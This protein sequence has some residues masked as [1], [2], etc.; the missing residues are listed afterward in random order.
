MEQEGRL[1]RIPKLILLP[2]WDP[3][4]ILVPIAR[5]K[6]AECTNGLSLGRKLYLAGRAAQAAHHGSPSGSQGRGETEQ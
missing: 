3:I 2:D 6:E 4:S 5:V 1:S